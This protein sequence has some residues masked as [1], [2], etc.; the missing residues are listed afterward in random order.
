[1]TACREIPGP[2]PEP[3]PAQK[4]PEDVQE[5]YPRETF[6]LHPGGAEL[7]LHAA[8]KA[9]L[10]TGERLLDIGCGTGASLALLAK[11]CGI[12]PYGVDLSERVLAVAGS[13]HPDISFRYG[14]AQ[15]LPFDG[16]FF[17]AVLMECVL[18]LA[19]RPEAALR[20]AVRVLRPGGRL[21]LSTLATSPGGEGSGSRLSGSGI[22]TDGAADAA[23]LRSCMRDLGC[24]LDYEEDRRADLTQYVVESIMAYG[25]IEERTRYEMK[26]T[27]ASVFDCGVCPDPKN[28]TYALFIFSK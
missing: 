26:E 18:T 27:G 22:I 8:E 10:K 6:S 25:S 21:I 5:G 12:E 7:T 1:M 20:E 3:Q 16:A 4:I 23:R 15:S 24:R 2:G 9:G 28:T 13:L 17:Q 11:T 19:E 14:A